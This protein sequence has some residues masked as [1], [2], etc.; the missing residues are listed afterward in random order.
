MPVLATDDFS[1]VTG[2]NDKSIS[3]TRVAVTALP[4][5]TLTNK[6]CHYHF[7]DAPSVSTI[8]LS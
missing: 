5:S 7:E 4:R 2:L 6:D 3:G 8:F 1:R